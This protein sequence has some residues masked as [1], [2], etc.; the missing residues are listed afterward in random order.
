VVENAITMDEETSG[1][2]SGHEVAEFLR[3]D[4]PVQSQAEK[5]L[6]RL[7]DKQA[8]RSKPKVEKEAPEAEQPKVDEEKLKSLAEASEPAAPKTERL[9]HKA[10]VRK[11]KLDDAADKLSGLLGGD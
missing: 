10:D 11:K 2:T 8:S 5:M 9:E 7:A 4:A 6:E 1:S 3:S